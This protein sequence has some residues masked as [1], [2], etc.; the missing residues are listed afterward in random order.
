MVAIFGQTLVSKH[1]GSLVEPLDM[2]GGEV[3]EHFVFRP[4]RI[5]P[6]GKTAEDEKAADKDTADGQ[7]RLVILFSEQG[8]DNHI[9][10]QHQKKPKPIFGNKEYPHR[11]CNGH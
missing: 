10:N 7:G 9:R 4:Q 8:A 5:H 2:V 3:V 1:H 11:R 6:F